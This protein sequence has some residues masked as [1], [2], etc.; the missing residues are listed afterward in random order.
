MLLLAAALVMGTFPGTGVIKA[1]AGEM[2]PGW[3]QSR[4]LWYWAGEDGSLHK[5]WLQT[6]G[7]TYYMD[8]NGVMV[9]GWKEVEGDWYYFH[10]DGGM[11]LGELIL[12][13]GKYEFSGSGALESARRLED[14]GGG[15]YDG[16]CYDPITQALFDDMNEEKKQLYFDL[17]PDWEGEE[18]RGGYDRNAGFQMNMALNKAAGRRLEV[19]MNHGYVGG[20]ITGEGTIK[21]YLASVHYREHA[22]CLEL[23]IRNCGD[24]GDAWSKVEE[25]TVGRY[26]AR[27]DRKYSLEYYRELG[28]AHGVKDGK[29]YFMIVFMR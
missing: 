28:M 6:D 9:L 13:N 2:H 11:N 23:Y 21:D 8:E 5:G 22:S 17:H 14:T 10:E 12:G 7:R 20:E 16:G 27:G 19:A 26:D 24:E 29:N 25:K 4:N 15:A 1:M 18:V 3:N